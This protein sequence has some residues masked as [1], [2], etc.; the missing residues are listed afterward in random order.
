MGSLFS[1]QAR[2]PPHPCL[3]FSREAPFLCSR[4][5]PAVR[6]LWMEKV[7]IW[8]ASSTQSL[9][10]PLPASRIFPDRSAPPNSRPW[11]TPRCATKAM[12]IS[13]CS[14]KSWQTH[15][16]P[17]R[18]AAQSQNQRAPTA[19]TS[20]NCSTRD[21]TRSQEALKEVES[22]GRGAAAGQVLEHRFI[23]PPIRLRTSA[24]IPRLIR[25][26]ATSPPR[27]YC[28]LQEWRRRRAPRRRLPRP[29]PTTTRPSLLPRMCWAVP[30]KLR[31]L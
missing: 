6:T 20:R 16:D 30:L 14:V 12:P 4:A 25:T 24:A 17:S 13:K 15:R 23:S 31:S 2:P 10:H 1:L 19:P 28:R 22:V 27:H 7:T 11:C 3:L 5:Q 29:T 26:T 18:S 21:S 8:S 9:Q